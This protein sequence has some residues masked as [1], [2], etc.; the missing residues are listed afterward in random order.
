[1]TDQYNITPE[2]ARFK[3]GQK[4]INIIYEVNNMG[5]NTPPYFTP[6]EVLKA[7]D[8]TLPHSTVIVCCVYILNNSFDNVG[9]T[10]L[11]TSI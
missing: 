1:M 3:S 7:S 5:D 8:V 2:S 11:P 10:A 6:F 9:H 4:Y